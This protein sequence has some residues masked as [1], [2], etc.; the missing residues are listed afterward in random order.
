MIDIRKLVWYYVL[1]L[2]RGFADFA[3]RLTICVFLLKPIV[4]VA[5]IAVYKT[6]IILRNTA[7]AVIYTFNI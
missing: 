6:A 7:R 3:E 5:V 1:V 2:F 4:V